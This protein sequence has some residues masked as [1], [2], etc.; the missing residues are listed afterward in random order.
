MAPRVIVVAKRTAYRRFVE[1]END[2]RARR[3]LR[4]RDP[5][6][7]SWRDS[8][9]AHMKTL[10]TVRRALNGKAPVLESIYGMQ[11]KGVFVDDESDD[12]VF[13]QAEQLSL[14]HVPI[15]LVIQHEEPL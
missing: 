15:A 13:D 14:Y 9:R 8:H 6:V 11:V 5:S 10:E 7:Q 12:Y 2:P 4:R 1:E 3:L